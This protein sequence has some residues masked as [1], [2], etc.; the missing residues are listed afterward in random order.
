MIRSVVKRTTAACGIGI[1]TVIRHH[2][3]YGDSGGILSSL[4]K[5]YDETRVQL[6]LNEVDVEGKCMNF[7]KERVSHAEQLDG[8]A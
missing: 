6:F 8:K 5:R 3:E 1:T 7:I 2:K 4:K